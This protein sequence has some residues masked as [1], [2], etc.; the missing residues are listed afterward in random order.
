MDWDA[1]VIDSIGGAE[2][3]RTPDLMTT[4]SFTWYFNRVRLSEPDG[5]SLFRF[6]L[7]ALPLVSY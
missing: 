5:I 7:L 3:D 2:G 6:E 1:R 4:H